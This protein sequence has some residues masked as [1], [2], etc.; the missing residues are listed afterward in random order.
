MDLATLLPALPDGPRYWCLQKDIAP[1]DR[2]LMEASGKIAAFDE[3]A[4]PDTAAQALLMDAVIAV[5]TSIAQLA[6]ALGCPTRI[7][8]AF[9]AD[10]RW[11]TGRAD[12]PWNPTARLLRQASPGDWSVPLH[13]VRAGIEALA[14]QRAHGA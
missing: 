1:A 4:F 7:L 9:S 2:A 14:M 3:N 8:L 6:C 5:D 10:Y 11:L 13:E 12:S